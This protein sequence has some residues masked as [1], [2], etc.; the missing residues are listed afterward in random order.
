M[1]SF[2]SGKCI[3]VEIAD[4]PLK[5][6]QGLMFREKL[7][8]GM[9]F[10]FET[11]DTYRFWMKNMKIPIDIVWMNDNTVVS[12][13]NDLQ[14]CIPTEEKPDCETYGPDVDVNKVL[15]INAGQAK[16]LGIKP[17]DKIQYLIPEE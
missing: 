11:K 10:I 4:T 15:E 6:K 17:G 3:N 14:P 7:D 12:I 1:C 16:E 8:G 9:L 13:K 2:D 5:Q